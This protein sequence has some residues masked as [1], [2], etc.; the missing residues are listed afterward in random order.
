MKVVPCNGNLHLGGKLFDL[1]LG[2]KFKI[3]KVLGFWIFVELHQLSCISSSHL[4]L[5]HFFEVLKCAITHQN[6]R[7]AYIKLIVT[8]T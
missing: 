4:G 1:E 3:G 7:S 8:P 6:D 5:M 2:L